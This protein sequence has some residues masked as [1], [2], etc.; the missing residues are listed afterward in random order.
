[1]AS[2]PQ[3]AQNLNVPGGG[4]RGNFFLY[5]LQQQGKDNKGVNP[6]QAR[7]LT[8]TDWEN[9][10]KYERARVEMRDQERANAFQNQD[11]LAM[12]GTAYG[13]TAENQTHDL[14][15]KGHA[16][17]TDKSIEAFERLNPARTASEESKAN[18]IRRLAAA[19]DAAGYDTAPTSGGEA[20]GEG[21]PSTP[22]TPPDRAPS[23]RDA[24]GGDYPNVAV[25]G[26]Q[27]YSVGGGASTSTFAQNLEPRSYGGPARPGR[28]KGK[29]SGTPSEPEASPEKDVLPKGE[30][31]GAPQETPP[32]K[33]VDPVEEAIKGAY[34]RG[35][36]TGYGKNRKVG[37]RRLDASQRRQITEAWP[38]Y[39]AAQKESA[40]DITEADYPQI[41]QDMSTNMF[42]NIK[43]EEIAS[44][45][46]G[47]KAQLEDWVVRK[48]SNTEP[49]VRQRRGKPAEA[50]TNP[51]EG[52]VE[53]APAGPAA[54]EP[55]GPPAKNPRKR[56]TKNTV[57]AEENA[58]A[59]ESPQEEAAPTED[60]APAGPPGPEAV[61]QAKNQK[62]PGAAQRQDWLNNL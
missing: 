10:T 21:E 45:T 50:P 13:M 15:I 35:A 42:A 32:P 31:E 3:N 9:M 4:G 53:E 61:K 19:R 14:N 5:W 2:G 16:D 43:P 7:G 54:E 23:Y 46:A 51:N 12:R 6:N 34:T 52:K 1:M 24:P 40:P 33:A 22:S 26:K 41:A 39:L 20:G 48:P 11:Q 25:T 55:A 28:E 44:R 47:Q 60:V 38:E 58:P 37:D 57:V 36:D 56:N 49:P 8:K 18:E 30:L 59:E 27:T 62:P 29:K 17:I